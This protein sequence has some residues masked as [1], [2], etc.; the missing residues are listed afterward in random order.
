MSIYHHGPRTEDR[1]LSRRQLLHRCG[2]GMGAIALA[3]LMA[4]VGFAADASSGGRASGRA[5]IKT[6]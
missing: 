4:Q 5:A 2:M 6:R 3:N 1:G